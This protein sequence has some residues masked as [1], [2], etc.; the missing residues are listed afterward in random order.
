MA[1][2]TSGQEKERADS[3][4]VF[5]RE[6]AHYKL[7]AYHECAKFLSTDRTLHLTWERAHLTSEDLLLWP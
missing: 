3:S 1:S 5:C 6:P 4:L 2:Q 7:V